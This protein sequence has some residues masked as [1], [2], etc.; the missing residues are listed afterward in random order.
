MATGFWLMSSGLLP[1]GFSEAAKNKVRVSPTPIVKPNDTLSLLILATDQRHQE[2]KFRTDVN[3]VLVMR[4]P[5]KKAVLVSVPRDLNFGGG[6]INGYFPRRGAP[7]T[8]KLYGQII[9]LNVDNYV[10]VMGFDSFVWAV[11]EMGSLDVNVERPFVD[12]SF[13]GDRENWGPLTLEFEKG[14]QNMDGERALKYARSRKGNNGEGSDF[15]RM[16]RQQ[17]LLLSMPDAFLNRRKS[18]VPF[19]AQAFLDLI[20][21]KIKTDLGV[22]EVLKL[23]GFLEDYKNWQV[24]RLVLDGSYVTTASAKN[25]GGAYTLLL[26]NSTSV[27]NFIY[28]NLQ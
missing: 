9:G 20:T 12:R 5:V 18:I 14:P 4:P 26:K 28:K 6:K 17:D 27:K 16:K 15:A 13:P 22:A 19:A 8:K 2:A 25:Y 11:G 10:A 23:Y 7:A 24:T 21:G 1:T 3:L